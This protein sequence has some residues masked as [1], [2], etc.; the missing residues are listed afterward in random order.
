MVY[1]IPSNH[2]E[3][4]LLVKVAT[5]QPEKIKLI[6]KDCDMMDTVFTDRYKTI[7]GEATFFVRMPVSGKSIY[8]IIYK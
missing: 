2:E 8:L 6:V 5:K 7:S 1:K 3:F 4:T